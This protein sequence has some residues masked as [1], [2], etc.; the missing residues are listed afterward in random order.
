[1][2]TRSA[3]RFLTVIVFAALGGCAL[4]PAATQCSKPFIQGYAS[5]PLASQPNPCAS[6]AAQ[7]K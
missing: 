7:Q 3:V 6:S 2:S 1:M 4:P 5:P